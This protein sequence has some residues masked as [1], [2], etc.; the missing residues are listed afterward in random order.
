MSPSR[1]DHG[2]PRSCCRGRS[3]RAS[4]LWCRNATKISS[5]T[6]G[7]RG[8]TNVIAQLPRDAPLT[9]VLALATDPV[10]ADRSHISEGQP[11]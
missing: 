7:A 1:V 6:R 2:T 11:E 8:I 10:N 5:A 4:S 9:G 3:A